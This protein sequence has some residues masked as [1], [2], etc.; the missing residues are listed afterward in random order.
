MMW[1]RNSPRRTGTYETRWFGSGGNIRECGI[2]TTETEINN[3]E[4]K[5]NMR[6]LIL[7]LG[8]MA[9]VLGIGG[10]AGAGYWEVVYDLAGSTNTTIVT[11]AAST[12][13]DPITG[14]YTILYDTP[15]TATAP[16]TGARLVA[17]NTHL[18]M[19]QNPGPFILTGS[20]NTVL[21]PPT[22]GT[23]GTITGAT[24]SGLSGIPNAVTGWIH[25]YDVFNPCSAAG[26]VNSGT[27]PM[28]PTASVPFAVG[29]LIFTGTGTAPVG[30]SDFTSTG[31]TTTI[32]P[33][34]G[35]PFTVSLITVYVGKEI[36][37]TFVPEPSRWMQLTA[38]V[39]CLLVLSRRRRPRSL[40]APSA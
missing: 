30:N 8:L 27:V 36:S 14:S 26:Y 4:R 20:I 15:G 18:S 16:I 22:G 11:A 1:G 33:T 21:T 13:I 31:V 19:S 38:G 32:P 7:L 5:K 29:D 3:D 35:Q 12:D 2:R 23:V 37:R 39:A 24:L 25:C 10:S 34:T 40:A 6:R 17:G 28:T 9:F